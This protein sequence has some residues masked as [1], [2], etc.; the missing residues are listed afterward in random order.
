MVRITVGDDDRSMGVFDPI[1]NTF[2]RLWFPAPVAPR[3]IE[4][5]RFSEPVDRA[6]VLQTT[7]VRLETAPSISV[8]DAR[9]ATVAGGRTRSRSFPRDEYELTL[10]TPITTYLSVRSK[11]AL[12]VTNDP[13]RRV[14]T[15][16]DFGTPTRVV[17]GFRESHERPDTTIQIRR[18]PADLAVAVGRFGSVTEVC[19]PNRSYPALREH[20]PL[21]EVGDRLSVPETPPAPRDDVRLRVP[22]TISHVTVAAPLAYYLGVPVVPGQN[23]GLVV[24]A[25]TVWPLEEPIGYPTACERLLHQ[26]LFLDCLARDPPDDQVAL[27]ARPLTLD[28]LPFDPRAYA[29]ASSAERLRAYCSVPFERIR[30]V[31]PDWEQPAVV[32]PNDRTIESLPYLAYDL[33]PIRPLTAG[34][35]RLV[36]G[37]ADRDSRPIGITEDFPAGF[38]HRH[39]RSADGDRVRIGIVCN[40]QAMAAELEAVQ[41]VYGSRDPFPV[42]VERHE[43]LSTDEL[44]AVLRTPFDFFHYIGHLD[45]PGLRC[46]DGHLDVRS[47]PG[48]AVETFFL[49][50]CTSA[51]QAAG[52]VRAGAVGGIATTDAVVN[53]GAVRMGEALARLLIRG[54][55]IRAALDL[56]REESVV[57]GSYRIVGDPTVA[58]ANGESGIPYRCHLEKRGPD[59]YRLTLETF[60]TSSAA[61]G[62]LCSFHLGT[63]VPFFLTPTTAGF[64]VDRETLYEFLSL[65]DVPVRRGTTV[66]WSS[67]LLEELAD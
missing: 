64:D 22:E 47:L 28:R 38:R 43:D 33:R 1:E 62:S 65:E 49:N 7:A 26:V 54:F 44:A 59:T 15:T 36:R 35:R 52:L 19:G 40:V 41:G 58:I 25:E 6:V 63:D 32:V 31:V 8:R 66:T 3:R 4:S 46:R 55:P 39:G 67:A 20:P 14:C 56:A 34:H 42:T 29:D 17:L 30:D 13:E 27:A 45:D 53:S 61:K 18:E 5:N 51:D 16:I 50:A 60:L 57:G 12:E 9:G 11:I 37:T 10:G 2:M 48:V 21:V 24:D 23:P